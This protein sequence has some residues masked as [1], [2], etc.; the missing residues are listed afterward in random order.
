[1]ELQDIAARIQRL[2]VTGESKK[3]ENEVEAQLYLDKAQAL[4]EE[5]GLTLLELEKTGNKQDRS[6]MDKQLKGGLY[7][8]QRE[9]WRNVAE[10]NFCMYWSIKGLTR[11]STYQHRV[12]GSRINALVAENLANYLQAAVERTARD[13]F[14][15][16]P[17]LYFSKDAIAYREGMAD[18]LSIRLRDRAWERKRKAEEKT[19]TSDSTA[20]TLADVEDSE[21]HLNQDF[22]YGWEPGTSARR[23]AERRA[24][25]MRW[26]LA[27]HLE[28]EYHKIADLLYKMHD[29]RGWTREQL[30][31]EKANKG[32]YRFYNRAEKPKPATYHEGYRK[33][34]DISLDDQ[35]KSNKKGEIE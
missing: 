8:W 35:I 15:N 5:Y 13:R 24:E 34:A 4:L 32:S 17:N 19:T 11:G 7:K 21:Y 27:Y 3:A 30:K 16:N 20:L 6:R 28:Q 31:K 29:P 9:L 18:R 12:L 1:M 26:W 10:T 23:A 25:S 33:G 2:I 14:D 22:L